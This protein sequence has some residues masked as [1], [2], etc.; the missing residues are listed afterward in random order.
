MTVDV[1]ITISG[2][3]MF[4]PEGNTVHVLLPR[5]GRKVEGASERD[6]DADSD[7]HDDHGHP[8]H[9]ARI[10]YD[11]AHES[12]NN[13]EPSGCYRSVDVDGRQIEVTAPPGAPLSAALDGGHLLTVDDPVCFDGA[14]RAYHAPLAGRRLTGRLMLRSGRAC[15]CH[16]TKD[17]KSVFCRP[18]TPDDP[19]VQ[20]NITEECGTGAERKSAM[21]YAVEW[22]LGE[23]EAPVTLRKLFTLTPL[24]EVVASKYRPGAD[25]RFEDVAERELHP[26]GRCIALKLMHVVEEEL[27]KLDGTMCE[28]QGEGTAHF[29]TYYDLRQRKDGGRPKPARCNEFLGGALVPPNWKMGANCGVIRSG[30]LGGSA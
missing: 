3:C 27:P 17:G 20:F 22:H 10:V 2:L 7:H 28:P 26:V 30:F 16:A 19:V 23:F 8:T 5:A 14:H 11:R 9:R 15:Y 21:A 13:A 24:S 25:S 1:R 18:L 29:D 6:V 12:R 4:V